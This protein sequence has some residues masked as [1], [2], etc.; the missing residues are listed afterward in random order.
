[1]SKRHR[2]TKGLG[3]HVQVETKLAE[4]W[5]WQIANP[6][7]SLPMRGFLEDDELALPLTG[8]E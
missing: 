1:M 2:P 4:V 5:R 8:L 3:E 6:D 7:A